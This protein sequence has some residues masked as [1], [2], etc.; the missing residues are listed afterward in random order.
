MA[1]FDK[2]KKLNVAHRKTDE[3]LYSAVAQEMEDG[4]RHNG[5]WLKAL[6]QAEGNKEKQIAEYIKLRVQSLKDDISIYS[7][8]GDSNNGISHGRDIEEF[9]TMLNGN[10][11]IV[12]I[13][14]YFSGMYSQD[15]KNFINVHDACEDYPIH[16]SVKRGRTDLTQW[17]LEAGANSRAKNYWGNTAL[18]IAERN[19]DKDALSLLQ[20]YLT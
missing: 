1:I 19:D 2:F 18:D 6:E 14:D 3:A 10:V 12:I 20:G 17:L 8:S 13:E 9:V 16:I 11:S 15:I 5:L 7:D 4:V